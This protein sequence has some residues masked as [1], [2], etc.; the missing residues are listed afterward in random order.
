HEQTHQAVR[1]VQGSPV[2]D[3]FKTRSAVV[4]PLQCSCPG[5]GAVCVKGR[6][7]QYDEPEKIPSGRGRRG[8][9]DWTR[10]PCPRFTSAGQ[11]RRA[12]PGLRLFQAPAISRLGGDGQDGG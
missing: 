3:I 10:L 11:G 1:E 6:D 12:A 9:G 8:C 5:G 4:P 2:T 7:E